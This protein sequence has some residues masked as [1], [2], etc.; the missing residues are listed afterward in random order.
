MTN[1]RTEDNFLLLSGIQHMAFCERQWALIHVEQVWAEN[2]RTIEGKHLHEH[3]DNP[4]ENE[5][6]KDLKIVRAMPIVSYSLGLRG[7]ADVV[8]FYRQ[9]S[10]CEA[11]GI[12]LENTG[13]WWMPVPVE[14]KRGHPKPD[15]RD[16]VQLCAQA[17]ALEEMLE[18]K[19][20]QG[21]LYYGQT[22]HREKVSLDA[23]LREHTISLALQMHKLM[24][25]GSTPKA[26]KGRRCSQCSLVEQC[27]PRL[28][29]NRKPV[30]EYLARMFRPEVDN[31]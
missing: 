29:L 4:F 8:E 11:S 6:R 31:Y 22:R 12:R 9:E 19:I 20:D 1:D 24:S 21:M 2:V 27:N 7:V 30:S 16:A 13:G 15:D 10:V 3:A 14:Y 25:E 18:V 5:S 17:I 28:S 26:Q 23:A